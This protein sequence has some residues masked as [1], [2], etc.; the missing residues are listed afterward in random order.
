MKGTGAKRNVFPG[1]GVS[2]GAKFPVAPVESA[3]MEESARA[4]GTLERAAG[5]VTHN[6][7]RLLESNRANNKQICSLL[8]PAKRRW[9]V[10]P[11]ERPPLR[12]TTLQVP[13]SVGPRSWNAAAHAL[14]V[15]EN[16][17]VPAA[18]I[19]C[20]TFDPPPRLPGHGSSY[21]LH[22]RYR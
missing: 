5:A 17:Q 16:K 10:F 8:A 4:G 22:R 14:P 7:G 18:G 6:T 1:Y 11:G 19:S 9:T 12:M 15:P 2:T 3:P 20:R 13:L 21:L